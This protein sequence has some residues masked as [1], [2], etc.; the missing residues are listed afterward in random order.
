MKV[1]VVDYK[2]IVDSEGKPYGHGK[3]VLMEAAAMC[4]KIGCKVIVAA[5]DS[6]LEGVPENEIYML[7]YAIEVK[8]YGISSYKEIMRNIHSALLKAKNM[9]SVIWFTNIDWF[10]LWYLGMHSAKCAK[11]IIVTSYMPLNDMTEVF[12]KKRLIIKKLLKQIIKHGLKKISMVI[13][14]YSMSEENEHMMY[15]PDYLYTKEYEQYLELPRKDYMLCI[16][17]MNSAKDIRGVIKAF[18][19]L[20]QKLIIS[21]KFEDCNEKDELVKLCTSNIRIMDESLEYDAYCRL[22]A[23]SKAVILP[24]KRTEMHNTSGVMRECIY[25]NTPV[26]A[27]QW[28]LDNMGVNLKGYQ[29]LEELRSWILEKKETLPIQVDLTL[30]SETTFIEKLKKYLD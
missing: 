2:S 28:L 16:G 26:I 18:S 22:I 14:T 5:S 19:G 9:Q 15:M 1:L 17:A 23:Q 11:E 4:K 27:P 3:K 25:L 7:P 10:L 12:R 13:Q 24:Y 30:F 29:K 21:G 6:Y 8:K 20:S